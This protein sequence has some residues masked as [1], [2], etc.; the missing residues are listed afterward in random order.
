MGILRR[1]HRTFMQQSDFAMNKQFKP[2][3]LWV[4]VFTKWV[5]G[6]LPE[7]QMCEKT[8]SV[9]IG[10]IHCSAIKEMNPCLLLEFCKG[11]HKIK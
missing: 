10:L 11:I 1:S 2:H 6:G 7:K 8:R 4:S 3:Y 9:G 5:G